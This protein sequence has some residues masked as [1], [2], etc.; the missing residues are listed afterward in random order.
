M[1][2]RV[3]VKGSSDV[4]VRHS[5][6]FTSARRWIMVS[7]S[8]PTFMLN[9]GERWNICFTLMNGESECALF[10]LNPG[11]RDYDLFSLNNRSYKRAWA[12]LVYSECKGL[13]EN[14]WRPDTHLVLMRFF[15]RVGSS[16]DS[17]SDYNA[18]G[19]GLRPHR[20]PVPRLTQP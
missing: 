7:V 10:L 8:V 20:T 16:G 9:I 13:P 5:V 17:A 1:H 6:W 3:R 15:C 2:S 18:D 12:N 14:F 19:R 11:N 4:S